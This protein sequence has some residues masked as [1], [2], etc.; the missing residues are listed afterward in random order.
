MKNIEATVSHTSYLC[1]FTWYTSACLSALLP[2]LS[3]SLSSLSLSL[4]PPVPPSGRRLFEEDYPLEIALDA[5]CSHRNSKLV[6]RDNI[7][8]IQWD[9]FTLPELT[10]FIQILQREEEIYA[11]KVCWKLGGPLFSFSSTSVH[12]YIYSWKVSPR[13]NFRL[14]H[15]GQNVYPMNVS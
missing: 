6:L 13:E 10:N 11:G 2:P 7:Y 3:L 5:S 8:S 9:T 4:S 15:P 1:L 14:F 12:I